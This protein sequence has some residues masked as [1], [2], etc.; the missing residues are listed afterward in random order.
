MGIS[1]LKPIFKLMEADVA[2]PD[3][4]MMGH[5]IDASQRVFLSSLNLCIFDLPVYI[6]RHNTPCKAA[7]LDEV[8]DIPSLVGPAV[9][10]RS[11][12]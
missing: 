9:S 3:R 12:I 1:R 8:T 7:P 6:L 4:W 10:H 2:D 5:V 11:G